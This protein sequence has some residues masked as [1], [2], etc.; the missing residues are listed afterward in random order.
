M[1][2]IREILLHLFQMFLGK[3]VI[4]KPGICDN[5]HILQV[6]IRMIKNFENTVDIVIDRFIF[7]PMECIARPQDRLMRFFGISLFQLF[8]GDFRKLEVIMVIHFIRPVQLCFRPFRCYTGGGCIVADTLLHH[9]L[10]I[11]FEFVELWLCF[12]EEIR[13]QEAEVLKFLR[14]LKV[15]S[16][17]HPVGLRFFLLRHI[18]RSHTGDKLQN[19]RIQ[20]LI[21]CRLVAFHRTAHRIG[22]IRFIIQAA[23]RLQRIDDLFE[24]A[25]VHDFPQ[26][27]L[28]DHAE[29]I[30]NVVIHSGC[31][32]NF[33]RIAGKQIHVVRQIFR[34]EF[35]H[36]PEQQEGK[37]AHRKKV[38]DRRFIVRSRNLLNALPQNFCG[39][40]NSL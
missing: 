12:L 31:S 23:G 38:L 34:H 39:R 16:G 11:G 21:F 8:P 22:R 29:F 27:I 5:L 26:H 6:F 15:F 33:F 13:I 28:Y 36:V 20:R 32:R 10:R 3:A 25:A 4:P 19:D 40:C 24:E 14:C 9:A 37:Q 1:H 30:E 18:R 17:G 7:F 35:I 2:G